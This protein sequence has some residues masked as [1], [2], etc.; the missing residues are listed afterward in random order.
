MFRS[1]SSQIAGEIQGRA[2]KYTGRAFWVWI[3]YQ[4]IKGTVTTLL[5]WLPLAMAWWG[6]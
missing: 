6:S 1:T 4:T 2:G 3:L 5:I